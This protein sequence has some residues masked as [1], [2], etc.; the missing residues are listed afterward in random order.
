MLQ[1]SELKIVI[2]GLNYAGLPLAVEFSKQLPV[3]G[4]NI[5]QKSIQELQSGQH[6]TLEVSVEEL[7]QVAQLTYSLNLDG[8]NSSDSFI[9][10][11][12]YEFKQSGLP[13]LINTSTNIEQVLKKV[14]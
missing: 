2:I 11:I 7:K 13:M 5:Q 8:L 1:R 3:V 12:G 4:F 6:H 10:T 14:M 9:L